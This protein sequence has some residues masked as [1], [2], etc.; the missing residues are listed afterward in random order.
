MHVMNDLP[1]ALGLIRPVYWLLPEHKDGMTRGNPRE[2]F[3]APD[4][5]DAKSR[6]LGVFLAPN[7]CGDVKNNRGNLRHEHNVTRFTSVF[8][9]IDKGTPEDQKKRIMAYPLPPSA[10]VQTGRGHHAYWI[11]DRF[12][13]VET[14][15][16]QRVQKAMA[17]LL[18]GD[19][20]CTDPARLMRLPG[21]WH[22]KHEPKPVSLVHLN[23]YWIYSLDEFPAAI[24]EARKP[25]MNIPGSRRKQIVNRPR[26]PSVTIIEEGMRHATLVKE[27]ARY[28]RGVA[29]TEIQERSDDL[30]AWYAQSSRPL[31]ENWQQE[32][33]DVIDWVLK[34]ELG[35]F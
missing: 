28:M 1:H 9:D 35:N 23:E 21:S 25:R 13:P 26:P 12:E 10:I 33:D 6:G 17:V 29:P 15:R 3:T 30:H 8:V 2:L 11:L 4:I 14:E 16:W 19:E 31:K 7:E 22:V 27:C 34:R 5:E 32:V 18:G 24:V 20:A